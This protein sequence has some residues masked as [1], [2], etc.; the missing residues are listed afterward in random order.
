MA[1]DKIWPWEDDFDEIDLTKVD[2]N[3]KEEEISE[4][5]ALELGLEK[6]IQEQ[7]N[8]EIEKQDNIK[9]IAHQGD[10]IT[11]NSDLSWDLLADTNKYKELPNLVDA[12]MDRIKGNKLTDRSLHVSAIRNEEVEPTS[13]LTKEDY[14]NAKKAWEKEQEEI[15]D[16]PLTNDETRDVILSSSGMSIGEFLKNRRKKSNEK[17][18]SIAGVNVYDEIKPWENELYVRANREA[19]VNA[20][21]LE[22]IRE[23]LK[24]PKKIPMES[25]AMGD[26]KPSKY[27]KQILKTLGI[28]QDDLGKL[29]S[30]SSS[31]TDSEKAKI[32]SAGYFGTK[33][34]RK[35]NNSRFYKFLTTGDLHY[36]YFLDKFK[37]AS[38][39][40]L[41]L[42]VGKS[43][44]SAWGTMMKLEKIGVVNKIPILNA[45]VI[46]GLTRTGLMAINS[47]NDLPNSSSK[48]PFALSERVY[49]N[50]FASCLFSNQINALNLDDFPYFGREFLGE[51]VRGE[52]LIPESDLMSSMY[53]EMANLVDNIYVKDKYKGERFKLMSE[54]WE[55]DWRVWENNGKVGSPE[56]IPG[57][58][59]MYV[60][61]SDSPYTNKFIVPDLVVKRP[62]N[63]DGSPGNIA[64]EVEKKQSS[65]EEYAKKLRVY[66]EDNRVY[67]K[68]VY[69]TPYNSV[70][71]NVAEAAQLLNFDRFDIVP[72][73]DENGPTRTISGWLVM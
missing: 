59:Y 8:K 42:A 51:K 13:T 53:K 47:E 57:N 32:M 61:F 33:E 62:R 1:N 66:K 24:Y 7:K 34:L 36:L 28:S 56:Q 15:K 26:V 71:K 70:A 5:E 16:D 72:P 45:P 6:F 2:L 41:A 12:P 21:R 17:E 18:Y 64:V 65:V 27:E 69:I 52:E 35:N 29:I 63:K 3:N 44:N 22:D 49:V 68:V 19:K 10:F 55:R 60:L 54:K 43:R 73:M 37:Y 4:E 46:W 58:E 30:P 67:S 11:N 31:L 40:N 38:T 25:L 48:A 14:A 9:P 50:Y 20:N 39:N 23:G